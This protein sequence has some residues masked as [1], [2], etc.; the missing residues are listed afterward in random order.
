MTWRLIRLWD[1]ETSTLS[2]QLASR[3]PRGSIKYT[4]NLNFLIIS[5]K[6]WLSSMLIKT[7]CFAGTFHRPVLPSLWYYSRS[8]FHLNTDATATQWKY[9]GINV[10]MAAYVTKF[11]TKY[12]AIFHTVDPTWSDDGR[13]G[14]FEER[15]EENRYSPKSKVRKLK[16]R[17]GIFF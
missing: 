5:C 12:Y 11:A 3:W 13:I 4:Y 10:E 6:Y 16:Q 2:R 14:C 1:V 15:N 9:T 7:P 8:E 17:I